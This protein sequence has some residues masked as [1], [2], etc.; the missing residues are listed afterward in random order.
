[1]ASKIR[2]DVYNSGKDID[3]GMIEILNRLNDLNWRTLH[4]CEGHSQFHPYSIKDPG[5]GKG[6]FIPWDDDFNDIKGQ[7][8]YLGG[9]IA[10]YGTEIKQYGVPEY[11][12]NDQKDDVDTTCFDF[13][14]ESPC[15]CTVF[16]MN[17]VPYDLKTDD[18]SYMCNDG[19]IRSRKIIETV[20]ASR[21]RA[22]QSLL[23]W[24]NTL[25]YNVSDTE[26][27]IS[28]EEWEFLLGLKNKS[29]K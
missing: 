7:H 13:Y 3:E 27:H 22:L 9:Y 16:R 19:L 11:W 25:P 26:H 15:F 5:W 8:I 2:F 21:E 14:T 18:E 6:A 24:V 1:M 17:Q 12:Y 10:I 29:K 20:N 28:T 23:S 4:C